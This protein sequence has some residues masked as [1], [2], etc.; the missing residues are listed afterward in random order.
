MKLTGEI[1]SIKWGI[2][3]NMPYLNIGVNQTF[4]QLR[5]VQIVKELN[6]EAIVYHIMCSAITMKDKKE[7]LGISF[8][9]KTYTLEPEEIV[10]F[11]PDEQ[12]NYVKI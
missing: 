7:E 3:P 1:K 12:H 2:I 4:G 9:W 11:L 10:Y 8:I 6:E 5:V